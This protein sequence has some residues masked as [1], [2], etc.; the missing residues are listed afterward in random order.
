MNKIILPNGKYIQL[1]VLSVR[2]FKI[3]T[4]HPE[5]F[6]K[7][8]SEKRF[9]SISFSDMLTFSYGESFD[10]KEYNNNINF[11]Y[12]LKDVEKSKIEIDTHYGIE[13]KLNKLCIFILPLL[14]KDYI[15]FD[16]NYSLY[17]GYISEDYNYL[18]L[19]YKFLSTQ[20]FLNLEEKLYKLPNFIEIYDPNKDF[21]IFKFKLKEK[22]KEDITLIMNGNYSLISDT[23]KRK[24]LLFHGLGKESFIGQVLYRNPA[25]K[26]SLERKIGVRLSSKTELM[27]KLIKENEIWTYQN[28]SQKIGT[29]N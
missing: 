11:N 3:Y 2:K 14:L 16:Y 22:D 15:Y 7:R 29:I 17:N 28:I 26:L 25:L 23:L 27:S 4:D 21:V 24:I 8:N 19:T 1:D 10:L 12:T 20:S 6:I 18:Y 5:I 9:E 13:G